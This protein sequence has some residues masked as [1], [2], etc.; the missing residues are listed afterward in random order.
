[1]LVSKNG[2]PGIRVFPIKDKSRRQRAPKFAQPGKRALR[3]LVA[4]HFK[5]PIAHNPN[6]NLI[7]FFKTQCF[8]D[9]GG[10]PNSQTV[11]PFGDMHRSSY[12]IHSSLY[13]FKSCFGKN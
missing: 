1:M 2:L 8:N 6:F 9:T 11:S 4:A 5:S 13:I 10:K 7:A 12:D 3:G